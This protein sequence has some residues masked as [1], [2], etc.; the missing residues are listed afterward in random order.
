MTYTEFMIKL[1]DMYK[2]PAMDNSSMGPMPNLIYAEAF[3]WVESTIPELSL[4]TFLKAI[5]SNF[6]PT[7]TVPFPLPVH[8]SKIWLNHCVKSDYHSPFQPAIGFTENAT[9]LEL[10]P[11]EKVAAVRWQDVLDD[12]AHMDAAA[13]LKKYGR[14]KCQ[15]VWVAL[16][17]WCNEKYP[18]IRDHREFMERMRL[19]RPNHAEMAKHIAETA[20]IKSPFEI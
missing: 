15:Q 5:F 4:Q 3:E 14:Q 20:K 6:G 10:P 7:S 2:Q 18:R 1:G 16:G 13:L 11:P 8:L 12:D 9:P 17:A 19:N